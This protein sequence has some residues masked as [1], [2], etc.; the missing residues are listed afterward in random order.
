MLNNKGRNN[1]GN[2][3][4]VDEGYSK[5]KSDEPGARELRR[6]NMVKKVK[7]LK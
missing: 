1:R 4:G 2:I 5:R 7:R 3:K 6:K